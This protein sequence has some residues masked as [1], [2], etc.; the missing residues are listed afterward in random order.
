MTIC[1]VCTKKS[2][3]FLRYLHGQRTGKRIRLFYC[4]YCRSLFNP[5]GY[6]EDEKQLILDKNWHINNFQKATRQAS[7]LLPKIKSILP[8]SKT[9]LDIGAGIGAIVLQAKKIGLKSEGIEP[10]YFAVEYA[11]NT[12]SVDLI[13]DYFK[14]GLFK[15]KFDI[16]TCTHVLEH[17]EN[18]R[19]IIKAALKILDRPGLLF[20]SVPFRRRHI[21]SLYYVLFPDKKGTPF[22][23]NDVHIIHFSRRCFN[24]WRRDFRADFCEYTPSRYGWVGFV[25]VYE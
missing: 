8:N 24:I 23:N 7:L 2:S 1:P 15:K 9:L 4:L 17:I 16:I 19:Y 11:K 22:H 25:F 14:N 10:N 20:I 21:K 18:P 13:C 6:K 12:F 5:S 3:L